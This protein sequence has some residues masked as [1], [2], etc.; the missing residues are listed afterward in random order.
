[1]GTQQKP[2][3]FRSCLMFEVENCRV[4]VGESESE[5]QNQIN[6]NR[7]KKAFDSVSHNILLKN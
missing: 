1:M 3:T 2:S 5:N 7:E 4:G 6:Q